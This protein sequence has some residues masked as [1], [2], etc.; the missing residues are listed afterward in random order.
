LGANAKIVY[1]FLTLI[2]IIMAERKATVLKETVDLFTILY[3]ERLVGEKTG[4]DVYRVVT[5]LVS[6]AD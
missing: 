4:G 3:N 6:C 5:C 1:P 2:D